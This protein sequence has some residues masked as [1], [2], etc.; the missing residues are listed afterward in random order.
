MDKINKISKEEWEKKFEVIKELAQAV[1][2]GV[3]V[4]DYEAKIVDKQPN[5][6]EIAEKNYLKKFNGTFPELEGF[7]RTTEQIISAQ[8]THRLN[9]NWIHKESLFDKCLSRGVVISVL[10]TTFECEKHDLSIDCCESSAPYHCENCRKYVET[11]KQLN[12]EI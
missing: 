12:I 1:Q 7:S 2:E 8:K 6:K 5:Y 11:L 3:I 10:R 4:V 9:H